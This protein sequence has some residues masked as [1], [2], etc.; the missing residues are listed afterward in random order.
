MFGQVWRGPQVLQRRHG[1]VT[2]QG[3]RGQPPPQGVQPQRRRPGQDA[4]GVPGPD[5]VPVLHPLDVVPH[6][7][8]V[9]EPPPGLARDVQHPP[10]DIGGNPGDHRLWRRSQP[11]G[12]EAAHLVMVAADA[13]RGQDNGLC[14]QGEVADHVAVRSRPARR[15][16]GGQDRARHA[17]DAAAFDQQLIDPATVV[18]GQPPIL[19]RRS[20]AV[21]EGLGHA[22][23][24]APGDVKARHG[25]AVP[26]GLSAA[27][28]GPA[29]HGGQ[30][31]PMLFQPGA[32]FAGGEL[33]IGARP[34]HRPL[35]LGQRSSQPVPARAAAPVP[36][37]QVDAVAHAQLPLLR[38]VDQE[39]SAEGPE[40]L[41]AQIGRVLLIDQRHPL[42]RLNQFIGGDQ[43][44]QSPAHDDDV[45]VHSRF[46][47]RAPWLTRVSI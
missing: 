3:G 34:L 35:I 33:D 36:P 19:R 25:I 44:G 30:A 11:L 23:P 46:P 24:G 38:R 39:Q 8:A 12:P 40:G 32:L 5:G 21:G 15:R 22:R 41:A 10:V 9:H 31:D 47:V 16:V 43:S 13:A 27:A 1:V 2:G 4:D 7:V 20:C 28:F 45:C 37:G 29:D 18:E 26:E 14:S 17:C 6:T 42:A